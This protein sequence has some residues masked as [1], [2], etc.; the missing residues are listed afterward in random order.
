MVKVFYFFGEVR[1]DNLFMA[2]LII[3]IISGLMGVSA[4]AAASMHSSKHLF[5]L[6]IC[7]T[8]LVFSFAC[9]LYFFKHNTYETK[10]HLSY[11]AFKIFAYAYYVVMLFV[12]LIYYPVFIF[13]ILLALIPISLQI[14]WSYYFFN[15]IR[16]SL[17]EE[18][19]YSPLPAQ[20]PA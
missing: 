11:F 20:P 2:V 16:K 14:W 5:S 17:P 8:L 12:L 10:M 9:L 6:L 18:A 3:D 4:S 13:F 7:S 19:K 1:A 15:D